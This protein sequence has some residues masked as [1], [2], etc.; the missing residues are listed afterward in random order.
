MTIKNLSR[1]GFLRATLSTGAFLLGANLLSEMAWP[2]SES[3][4][5]AVFH[6]SVFLGIE[7]N[8]TVYIVAH[9]SEVGSGSRT[10]LP[11][12]VADELDA[13]WSRVRIE[14][15]IGDD[16]YGSQ[17]SEASRSIR[18]FFDPMREIGASARLMLVRA[19]ALHWRVPETECETG[20]HAVLHRSSGSKLE[21]GQLAVTAASLPVPKREELQFKPRRAWHYIGK[22]ASS[23]DLTNLCTGRALYGI[24]AH[25]EGMLYT[26]IERPPV[27]GG[28]VRSLD[29]SETL[30]VPGVKQTAI[31]ET[32]KP[33]Y[34]VQPVGGVAVIAENTWAAIKGRRRLKVEWD[35]GPNGS[36][37][38]DEYKEELQHAV[39]Q[40]GKVVRNV[41][42]VDSEFAKGGK[43]VE[44]EYYVPQLAHVTMEPPTALVD[45]RDGKVTAWASTQN[46]QAVQEAIAN[47][48]GVSKTEV[49]C[50]VPLLGGGFGR[51]SYSDFAVEA[52][53]LSKKVG[54]PIKVLWTR[55]DDIKHDYY[56]PVSVMYIKAAIDQQG[57]P[58]AWLQRVAFPPIASNY[59][60]TA[61]YGI[62]FEVAGITNQHFDVPNYRAE[63]APATAHLRIG[64]LR[65]VS[66][67]HGL[68]ATYSFTDELAHAS[69]RDPLEYLLTLIGPARIIDPKEQFPF[70]TGRLLHVLELAAEKAAWGKR[71]LGTG[72]GMGI[73]AHRVSLSYIATVVQVEVSR[74]GK[75]RIP[76]I[77]TAV[78]VGTVVNPDN[79]RCQI[80]GAAVFGTS[81]ARTGEITVSN[82]V[83]DQSNFHDY[84]VARINEV[85]YQNNVYVVDS[86]APPT[87]VG[88]TGVPLILPALC[89]AIFAATGQRIRQLP[90]SRSEL[91]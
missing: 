28:R 15:A 35:H 85:P 51:K 54:R 24:D 78:D 26:S 76:R 39:R 79:V 41:G 55:E 91:V 13:D 29:N 38:S 53:I 83:I 48:V 11:R 14:Q 67:I 19:A 9:R 45:Y 36:H 1:R 49:V 59:D 72:F 81:I 23:Y 82:G 89:N 2:E 71:R 68:F 80:E 47:A 10:A 65:S 6:P 33:P 17:D 21:Y 5:Q 31:I 32:F 43:I 22:D 57:M 64:I 70:D 66:N 62:D 27:L 84:P 7:T 30:R 58:K 8:G 75:L 88:E 77:D 20:L 74:D 60:P 16:R 18:Q 87:G 3:A 40:P 61:R 50:H 56:H 46:P 73:A 52:A 34:D 86:S 69:G 25:T 12:V 4:T 37:R 42:D 63:N 90:L 44:S